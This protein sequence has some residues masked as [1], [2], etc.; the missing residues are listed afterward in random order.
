MLF[1][2]VYHLIFLRPFHNIH[3]IILLFQIGQQT[4]GSL[5][6]GCPVRDA[7]RQ[8]IDGVFLV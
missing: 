6:V 7:Y 1:L 8:F 3:F 5:V 4:F 2:A